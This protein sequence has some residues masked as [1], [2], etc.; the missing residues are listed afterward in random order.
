MSELLAG[1]DHQFVQGDIQTRVT[2]G[3]CFDVDRVTPG[4]LYIAVPNHPAGGV[5]FAAPALARGAAAVLVERG[6]IEPAAW[7]SEIGACVV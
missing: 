3:A 2:A 6:A 1:V 5:E 7:V 4:A